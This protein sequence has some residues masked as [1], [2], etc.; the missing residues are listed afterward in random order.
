MFVTEKFCSLDR[1]LQ[2]TLPFLPKELIDL[3]FQNKFSSCSRLISDDLQVQRFGFECSLSDFDRWGDFHVEARLTPKNLKALEG[4]S[5]SSA[6]VPFFKKWTNEAPILDYKVPRV[7]FE[8]DCGSNSAWPPLPNLFVALDDRASLLKARADQLFS[9]LN[10]KQLS[11]K[12]LTLL[13]RASTFDF[14]FHYLGFMIGRPEEVIRVV[15]GSRGFFPLE[16]HV[17]FL[18][19]LG[20]QGVD[21]G[22][23]LLL[24]EIR[25]HY[26]SRTHLE[27]DLCRALLPRIGF[28]FY[29]DGEDLA[30]TKHK[31]NSFLDFLVL[32]GLTNLQVQSALCSWMENQERPEILRG[33][34]HVKILFVPGHPLSGKVYLRVDNLV[35]S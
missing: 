35:G 23:L 14:V 16:L 26:S 28:A 12:T 21:A 30:A 3:E 10:Q 8:F 19:N 4:S 22:S 24:N 27:I 32:H 13:E 25:S 2:K 1:L 17:N 15:C 33:I 29:I 7:I 11:E 18:K 5:S 6:L 9:E 20:H 31:W 34:S